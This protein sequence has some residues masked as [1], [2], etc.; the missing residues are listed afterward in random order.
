MKT[1]RKIADARRALNLTQEQLA[2]Q[3]S[4]T[5]QTVSR[6]ESDLSYP[7]VEKMAA[8]ARILGVSCDYL[9]DDS[10]EKPGQSETFS[11]PD[12]SKESKVNP[13]TRLLL[14]A[15]GRPVR[16]GLYEDAEDADL[17]GEICRILD[18]DG[19]WVRVAYGKG[20]RSGEKLLPLSSICAL[21][22]EKEGRE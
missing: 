6:W 11:L 16:L 3:M 22:F 12:M 18:F 14:A 19:G 2:E 17:I 15:A 1:G 9:L 13:V 10:I 7:E 4:V 5:R 20:K 21:N 8:L